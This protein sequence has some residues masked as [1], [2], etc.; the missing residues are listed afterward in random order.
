M[1]TTLPKSVPTGYRIKWKPYLDVNLKGEPILFDS[2]VLNQE[3]T[4]F[5]LEIKSMP[6]KTPLSFTE[7]RQRMGR[8]YLKLLF[9]NQ[10]VEQALH[11][12]TQ[13]V[14]WVSQ[15][16]YHIELTGTEYVLEPDTTNPLGAMFESGA[17]AV[18]LNLTVG[19]R[20]IKLISSPERPPIR[21]LHFVGETRIE[22]L[23][24]TGERE[25][26]HLINSNNPDGFL[27]DRLVAEI[28]RGESPRVKPFRWSA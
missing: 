4:R 8:E 5:F 14:N 26:A 10:Q 17:L 11:L 28:L 3:G 24:E 27:L 7:A 21:D 15:S 13:W 23:Y 20:K 25:G 6:R 12:T 9:H 2:Q 18:K 16:G 19:D 22:I 1:S